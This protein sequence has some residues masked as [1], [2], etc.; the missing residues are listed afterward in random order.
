MRVALCISGQPRNVSRGIENIL[1]NM[2]FEVEVFVHAWWDKNSNKST[3]KKILYNGVEDEVSQPMENDWV[4][5]LY[6]NFDVN[7]I[8]LEKQI[9]VNVP[10]ILKKRKLKFTYAFGVCSSLYSIYKCNQ[11]KKDF[12]IEN[13]FEYDW[14]IRTRSD[15]GLSE[16]ISLEGLDNSIIYAPNDNSHSYGFNDQFAIGSSKNMDVYSK[17]FLDMEKTIESHDSGIKTAN[18]CDKPDN[19]GHEQIIQKHLENNK[20]EFELINFK[21]YLFRDEDKRTRIHSV[22]N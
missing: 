20:I 10:E 18:Y 12:E 3:F 11:L 1:E 19:V 9:N 16:P 8:L 21:N 6:N 7:K 22:E 13:N 17:T 5:D 2:N 14:V 4:A 15:F